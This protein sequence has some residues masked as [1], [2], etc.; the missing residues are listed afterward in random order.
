M[1][2]A[3]GLFAGVVNIHCEL[4]LGGSSFEALYFTSFQIGFGH[5]LTPGE[6]AVAVLTGFV[7]RK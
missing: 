5:F 2:M 6:P 3:V 4:E 1:R 7:D